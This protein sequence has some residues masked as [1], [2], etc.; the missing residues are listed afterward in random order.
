[1]YTRPWHNH[2]CTGAHHNSPPSSQCTRTGHYREGFEC[3]PDNIQQSDEFCLVCDS[4]YADK[5]PNLQDNDYPPLPPLPLAQSVVT[6]C[7]RRNPLLCLPV[8]AKG[9][10]RS[11]WT[12]EEMATTWSFTWISGWLKAPYEPAP[13]PTTKTRTFGSRY[14]MKVGTTVFVSGKGRGPWARS[15]MASWRAP[16]EDPDL[17]Q[18]HSVI[19]K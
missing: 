8:P 4:W 17:P 9:G 19:R 7:W 14:T 2:L 1:M 13:R 12:S 15:S 18:R 5:N 10:Y 3:L 16:Q 6:F 11:R